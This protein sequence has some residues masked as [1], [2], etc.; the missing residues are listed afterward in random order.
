MALISNADLQA[1]VDKLARFATEAVGDTDFNAAFN[2]GLEAASL[3]VLSGAGSIA[4]Y[5]LDTNDIDVTADLL[6]AARDL[7]ETHPTAPAGFILGIASVKAMLAAID[8][9]VKRYGSATSLD[10]YLLTLNASTPTLRVHANYKRFLKTM[11]AKNVFIG[12]DLDI[13]RVNVTGA[14][15]GTYTHLAAISPSQY[16][17]AK[18][19]AKNV[20]AITATTALS[21]TGKKFD[22]S[23]SVLTVSIATLTD[24]HETNLSSVLKEFIDVTGITVV[25]GGTSGNVIKIVAK[26][27]RDISA[28]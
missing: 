20:G 28:A 4:Q 15:A 7:D 13:A 6:P 11:S 12:A 22:L 3:S 14:A 9:H 25:S 2:S 18:L 1:I 8:T 17:G 21:V 24:G 23:T 19:V 10:D 26:T 16:A 27:D 5:L